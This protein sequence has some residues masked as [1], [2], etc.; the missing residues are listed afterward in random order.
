MALLRLS[1]GADVLVK[2]EVADAIAAIS[3]ASGDVDFVELPGE[4]GP[5]HLRPS[6]VIAV[7]E[8]TDHKTTGFRVVRD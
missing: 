2:L 1:N 4:E 6:S 7:L 3:I 5:I 8:S